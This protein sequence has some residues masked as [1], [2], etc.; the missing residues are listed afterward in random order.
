MQRFI[1]FLTESEDLGQESRTGG[2]ASRGSFK[3]GI[4]DPIVDYAKDVSSGIAADPSW[5][6]KEYAKSLFTDPETYHSAF[7]AGGMVPGAGEIFDVADAG[8]YAAQGDNE[9]AKFSLAAGLP[10]VG[11][12]G[13]VAR[14]GRSAKMMEPMLKAEKAVNDEIS[15]WKATKQDEWFDTT[16][17]PFFSR[18]FSD[19]F[20]A[21][22]EQIRLAQNFGYQIPDIKNPTASLTPME[23][24]QGVY[25]KNAQKNAKLAQRAQEKYTDG[26]KPIFD[27]PLN[28][29]NPSEFV[30]PDYSD[31]SLS[32]KFDI[33]V[34]THQ[35]ENLASTINALPP[36]TE[37][38]YSILNP[39][40]FT[41]NPSASAGPSWI[42]NLKIPFKDLA[43]HEMTHALGGSNPKTPWPE[44][45]QAYASAPIDYMDLN[46]TL[47]KK[48]GGKIDSRFAKILAN[49]SF[50]TKIPPHPNNSIIADYFRNFEIPGQI[51]QAKS[52][53]ERKGLPN[54]NMNMSGEE[55]R[56]LRDMILDKYRK[57]MFPEFRRDRTM[58][59]II[60][61][62]GSPEGKKLFD[63][64]AKK[65]KGSSVNNKIV[66][67]YA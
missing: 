28:P 63:M 39:R 8:L 55:A 34:G 61:I 43:A 36:D 15:T 41:V 44:L 17:H 53:M 26:L 25:G 50:E 2:K 31:S 60:D 23:I 27:I 7:A 62:I 32:K 40:S 14:V 1:S 20:P 35:P 38:A 58:P 49:P 9:M 57:G 64:I 13:N 10:V 6:G 45:A 30:I 59:S 56:V 21:T 48:A 52:W 4:I 51:A 16:Q 3:K 18:K 66:Q 37:A 19:P 29:K 11:A 5:F 22:D 24:L 42:P 33:Y 12:I 54:V 67:M 65:E 47:V 46:N